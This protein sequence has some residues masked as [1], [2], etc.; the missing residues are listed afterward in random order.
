MIQTHKLH[1]LIA[2]IAMIVIGLIFHLTNLSYNSWV[3]YVT[4]LPLLVL[5]IINAN[6]FSKAND[7]N[8]TFGNVFSSGFKLASITTIIMVIWVAISLQIFPE[9]RERGTEMAIKS[10][11]EK[12][13]SEE[14]IE[15]GLEMTKK[16]FM[17]FA[18]GGM[19]FM[20]LLYGAIFSLIGAAIAKK[21]PRQQP[22]APLQ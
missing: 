11:E 22:P 21:N 8:V 3:Q 12:G 9:I 6:A 13:L 19:L 10:M 14:Q 20:T 5:T 15:Q 2:G 1:G 4:M 16:F 18:I 7:T 17:V